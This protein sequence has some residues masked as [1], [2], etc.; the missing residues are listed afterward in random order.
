MGSITG[1]SVAAICLIGCLAILVGC[2]PQELIEQKVPQPVQELLGGTGGK[3]PGGKPGLPAKAVVDIVSPKNGVMVSVDQDVV[4]R[5]QVKVPGAKRGKEPLKPELVWKLFSAADKKGAVIGKSE[6]V[7]KKLTPGDY[8]VDLSITTGEGASVKKASFKVAYTMDGRITGMD[9]KGMPEAEILVTGGDGVKEFFKAR[10]NNDGSFTIA[11]PEKGTFRVTPKRPGFSFMPLHNTLSFSKTAPV[12]AFEGVK[13]EIK[14]IRLLAADGQRELDS[15]C[16]LQKVCVAFKMESEVKAEYTEAILVRSEKGEERIIRLDRSDGD[17][18]KPEQPESGA[19]VL[20]LQ[21]PLQMAQE[22][23]TETLNLRI[24]VHDKHKHSFVAEAPFIVKYDMNRCFT[25]CLAEAVA[26]QEQGQFEEAIKKYR[27][28]EEFYKKVDNPGLF[29]KYMRKA[30]FNKGLASLALVLA[31]KPEDRRQLALLGQAIGE[32]KTV[33]KHNK[34]DVDALFLTGL[35]KQ[36]AGN[37]DA[38][39]S[40]YDEVLKTEPGMQGVHELRA[41][42]RLKTQQ[43]KNLLPAVDDLTEAIS[44]NPDA[45]E[46]RKARSEAL[47]LS[48]KSLKEARNKKNSDEKRDRGERGVGKKGEVDTSH[49]PSRDV[50]KWLDTAKLIRK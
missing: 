48:L 6:T 32:F 21:V 38:A 40:D 23:T 22:P 45:S 20:R 36:L 3:R 18:T 46:L 17:S 26:K 35:I 30:E 8:K 37:P 42:A 1:R 28:L 43:K 27:L 25:D 11:V 31:M 9:G 7:K 34:A 16:P 47:Q 49:I 19:T 50:G 12:L 39:V 44:R 2:D 13:G 41:L 14:N 15:V 4:F 33:L 5:A 10:T 29:S 24:K